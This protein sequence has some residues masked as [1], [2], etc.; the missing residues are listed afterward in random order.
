[1]QTLIAQLSFIDL[2]AIAVFLSA[3][4]S[5]IHEHWRIK[6]VRDER[7]AQILFN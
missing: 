7:L 2:L 1:M 3:L 6:K 5:Q 4:I